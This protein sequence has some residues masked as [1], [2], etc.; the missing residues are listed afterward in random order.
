MGTPPAAPSLL[1]LSGY[2][3]WTAHGERW[4]AVVLFTTLGCG[5]TS[6]GPTDGGGGAP[7]ASFDASPHDAG[8]GGDGGAAEAGAGADAA[9]EASTDGSGADAGSDATAEAGT[10]GSLDA[11]TQSD[12]PTGD[13]A[14][15]GTSVGDAGAES[16][17]ADEGAAAKDGATGPEACVPVLY[18]NDGD[19]DGY[20]GTTTVTQ[21]DPPTTGHWVTRG[22]DC[23]DSNAMVSPG[24]AAYFATG[25]VPTGQSTLSFDYDCDG[26]ESESGN[27]VHASCQVVALVCGGSGYLEAS[28]ARS[29]T[30]VDPFCGSDQA[31]TCAFAGLTC[32]AGSP[33]TTGPIA[34]R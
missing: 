34:C 21:C 26:A 15:D 2:M 1:S 22:G 28:P 5:G 33:Y 24:Q 13:G 32:K 12:G 30:G 23:D 25:Y 4:V 7:E 29:G 17:G 31:V 8:G 11:S 9:S 27:A 18:F 10:D 19:D 3:D 20:G 16:D 14:P 6:F